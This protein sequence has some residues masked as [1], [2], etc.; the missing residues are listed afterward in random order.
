[1]RR[2]SAEVRDH[3][4]APPLG[5]HQAREEDGARAVLAPEQAAGALVLPHHQPDRHRDRHQDVGDG[6]D[7]VGLGPLVEPEERGQ[8]LEHRED[9]EAEDRDPHQVRRP[10]VRAAACESGSARG[11][12]IARPIV[13][14]QS[15]EAKAVFTTWF[16]SSP[17]W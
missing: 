1:M 10:S 9:P 12:A 6:E 15:S 14:V 3:G 2:Q 13:V 5:D 7:E 4:E 8:E 17:A 16:G 11:R